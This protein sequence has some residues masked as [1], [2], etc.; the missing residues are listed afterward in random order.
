MAQLDLDENNNE[1]YSY[2]INKLN[3]MFAEL[4][5]WLTGV[6]TA[7]ATAGAATLN[8]FTGVIT[9]E[10]LTTVAGA[11]YEL[12]LTNNKV[13]A[14]DVV[15]AQVCGD[16]TATTGEPVVI[17]THPA[18]GSVVIHVKNVSGAAAI[19]GTVKIAFWV[20]KAA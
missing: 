7:T 2:F 16:G 13:A 4:F 15:F 19:N 6:G 18:A 5:S 20:K 14:A 8:A 9:T 3:L 10:A 1:G 11:F 12:T 17:H